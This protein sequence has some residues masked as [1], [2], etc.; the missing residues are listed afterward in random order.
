MRLYQ[1]IVDVCESNDLLVLSTGVAG[2]FLHAGGSLPCVC[3][4]G[5]RGFKKASGVMPAC[6]KI[7]LNVPS[8]ISPGWLGMV[9]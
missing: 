3:P 4:P 8:G 7:A 2:C 5:Y 6:F 1:H 9:V